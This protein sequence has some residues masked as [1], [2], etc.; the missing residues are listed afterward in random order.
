MLQAMFSGVSGLQ[1]HQTRL[2]VIGNNIANVNTIGF[3]AGRVTFEDQLSQT[4]RAAASPSDSAG[5]QNPA[6]VG[7][8]T[9]LGAVDTLQTQGNLQTTGKSTDMA[10]QGNGF[11]LVARGKDVFY[12]RDGSFDLDSSGALVNSA[13]GVKLLGYIAD[14]NGTIDTTQQLDSASTIKIPIGTLTSVKQT[15]A[16]VFQGNLSASA[17]LQSTIVNLSGAL[18]V[19]SYIL[20]PPTPIVYNTNSYDALG[21]AHAVQITFDTPTHN[22]ATGVSTW[23]VMATI[24]GNPVTPTPQTLTSNPAAGTFSF[25]GGVTSLVGNV[26]GGTGAGNFPITLDFS[27]LADTMPAS[28]ISG[29]TNGQ[30]TPPIQST[31]LN[32]SGTLNLDQTAPFTF[33]SPVFDSTG[34]THNITTTFQNPTF[35]PTGAG[36]PTGATASWDVTIATGATTLYDSTASN[37]KVYFV[38]GTGFVMADTS[39]GAS[40]GSVINLS[41]ATIGANN[42]GQQVAGGL[43]ISM[44]LSKLTSTKA[45]IAADGLSGPPAPTWSTSLNVYDSLGVKHD[46]VFKYQRVLVGAGAP[47]AAT[48]RWEWTAT[49]NGTVLTDS[50]KGNNSALFFDNQGKLLKG[51]AQSVP[52]SPTTGAAGFKVSVDFSSISQLADKN[53]SVTA[54]SQDGFA[55]GTLQTFSISPNGLIT[56]VFS[57]GQSRTLGQIASAS[58]SNPAGLEK[59]GE[60]LFRESSNSGLA[61]VGT[62]GLGGRGQISSGYVEMS[63]VD[64]STEFTNLIITQRGFQANTRIVSIV[65]DLLQDVINL[66]R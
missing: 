60:N 1:V 33:T 9:S 6:Q 40:L 4:L 59:E 27:K 24:D 61:Q 31:L 14:N 17:A 13:T 2:D 23:Q 32:L 46:I 3:K 39:S 7:L 29:N 48:S 64:L 44:D 11:F 63:N 36:V 37:S 28:A 53:S 43:P 18:D 52:L 62:A 49:E 65:D 19:S 26:V 30:T 21:N 58:F 20:N 54:S 34:A 55:V 56:G 35:N 47:N 57:N 42:Q 5:G 38:P 10:L 16:S 66:K 41:G 15:T 8:G 22:N 25:A 51:G 50:T 12:T 45:T